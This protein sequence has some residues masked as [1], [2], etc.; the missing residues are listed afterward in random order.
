MSRNCP[1]WISLILQQG[2]NYSIGSSCNFVFVSAL[3]GNQEVQESVD[4][5]KSKVEYLRT[6]AEDLINCV[7]RCNNQVSSPV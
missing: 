1:L 3:Q 6:I 5:G 7:L 4:V 2:L